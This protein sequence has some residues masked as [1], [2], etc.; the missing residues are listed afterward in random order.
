MLQY[1]RKI[2]KNRS[3]C[4]EIVMTVKR[5]YDH[6]YLK[7][8]V[9]PSSLLDLRKSRVG[10]FIAFIKTKERSRILRLI[11]KLRLCHCYTLIINT[12]R[13]FSFKLTLKKGGD[14]EFGCLLF[15]EVVTMILRLVCFSIVLLSF[16]V[17]S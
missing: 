13:A 2:C 3:N 7:C 1:G 14:S 11:F 5:Y 8:K 12:I 16:I 4:F 17:I 15:L 9:S 10:Q 6:N